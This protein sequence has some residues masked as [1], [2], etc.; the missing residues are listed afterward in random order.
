ML[1]DSTATHVGV[2][3]SWTGAQDAGATAY[4]FANVRWRTTTRN[5][6]A[7]LEIVR[8]P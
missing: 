7:H 3:D 8:D 5:A 6:H 4:R 1:P 2:Y